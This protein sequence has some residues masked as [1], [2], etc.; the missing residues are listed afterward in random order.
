[1]IALAEMGVSGAVVP[2]GSAG[3]ASRAMVPVAI[4]VLEGT[5]VP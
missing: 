1:V 2:V 4:I 5:R 3:R